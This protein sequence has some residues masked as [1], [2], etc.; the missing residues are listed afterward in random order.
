MTYLSALQ[1]SFDMA[2]FGDDFS[3]QRAETETGHDAFLSGPC[4]RFGA[5]DDA[6]ELALAA[7]GP[8]QVIWF[9]DP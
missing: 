4:I 6:V 7:F 3:N 1:I 5:H 2:C 9:F 8:L